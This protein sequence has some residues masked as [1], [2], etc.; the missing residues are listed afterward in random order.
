[1]PLLDDYIFPEGEGFKGIIL[2]ELLAFGY[3]RMQ[4]LMFTTN[5]TLL[6]YEGENY[7]VFWLRTKLNQIQEGKAANSIREKCKQFS[8]KYLP[9]IIT[10][11]H[12]N[13]YKLYRK[14][15]HF[16]TCE[17]CEEYLHMT[18]FSNPFESWMVEIRDE[19][20]LIAVG[21]FDKGL[22]TIAG[23]M[24]FYHPSYTKYSLGKYLILN[25]IDFAKENQL[26]FYYTGYISTATNKFDYKLFPSVK[27][28][29]VFL[30]V[31]KKWLPYQF[32][33]KSDLQEYY[34]THLI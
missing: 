27:A 15:V 26:A 4:H 8:V 12:N 24:N 23:I 3:Y 6:E 5:Q 25:K 28:I 17:S 21:Y 29:E 10:Q 7:P 34:V 33:E 1:M 20:L 19:N 9:A 32:F 16:T 22:T 13:L 11:E 14:S 31:E 18:A 30:P 2:D